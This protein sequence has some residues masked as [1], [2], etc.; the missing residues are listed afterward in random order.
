MEYNLKEIAQKL[1]GF[2][3]GDEDVVIHSIASLL[4]AK[5]G[6]IAFITEKNMGQ[7]A[8][9]KASALIVP[10][11]TRE[12]SIPVI[13]VKNPR[14]AFIHLIMTFQ[15]DRKSNGIISSSTI[16]LSLKSG[17][18]TQVDDGAVVKEGVSIGNNSTIGSNSFIG[19]N[20][21][22]GKNCSIYPNVTI[23]KDTL[24]GD[25]VI[26][27]SCSVIGSD[28]FGYEWDGEKHLKFPHIG[29]VVIGDDVEIGANTTIER[30]TI[31]ST[32][33]KKGTKI[34]NMVVIGHNVQIGEHCIVV[35]TCAIA[36]SSKIGNY[37]VLAGGCTISNHVSIGDHSVV[38]AKSGVAKDL[39]EKSFVSGIF[40][41]PHKEQ[42]KEY[43]TLARL[44]KILKEFNKKLEDITKTHF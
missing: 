27:Q 1:N 37:V 23:L 43:A 22:I 31:D 2:L 34:G 3:V 4:N 33:I 38:L 13:K 9:C 8:T 6:Q 11:N 36:G 26:I 35:S 15:D 19:E 7:L 21:T 12:Y 42:L 40:A 18:C 28:G 44:P 16:D 10:E 29:N 41:R 5:I 32:I 39:P 24:I 20:V 17:S 14:L 25:N 30:G